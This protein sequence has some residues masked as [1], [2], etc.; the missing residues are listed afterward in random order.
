MKWAYLIN[1]WKDVFWMLS[2]KNTTRMSQLDWDPVE[3]H[4]VQLQG[5]GKKLNFVIFSFPVMKVYPA[6]FDPLFF[7]V[8][9]RH[10]NQR[11]DFQ[12]EKNKNTVMT[13]ELWTVGLRSECQL[14]LQT[15]PSGKDSCFQHGGICPIFPKC[16]PR[17][18]KHLAVRDDEALCVMWTL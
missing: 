2:H 10:S 18:L 17:M 1:M 6:Y 15:A 5:S 11:Q 9:L 12:M 16:E 4:L 7:I 3:A 13:P 8:G 14:L